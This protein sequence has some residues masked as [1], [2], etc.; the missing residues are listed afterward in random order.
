MLLSDYTPGGFYFPGQ[1]TLSFNWGITTS[2]S[3]INMYEL[4]LN[5]YLQPYTFLNLDAYY[6]YGIGKRALIYNL[7]S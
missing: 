2:Y 4:Q 1:H 6:S 7:G 3:F 5:E